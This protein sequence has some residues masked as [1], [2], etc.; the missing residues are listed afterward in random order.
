MSTSF[1]KAP[2]VNWIVASLSLEANL[3]G[4]CDPQTL[5]EGL[6]VNTSLNH[7]GLF[8]NSIESSGVISVAGSH[9][10]H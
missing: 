2:Q 5:S 8:G 9:G 1:S 3:L 4:A 6:R 7:M 10:C